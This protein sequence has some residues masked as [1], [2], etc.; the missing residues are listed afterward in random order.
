MCFLFGGPRYGE[1][2]TPP[3]THRNAGCFCWVDF[4]GVGGI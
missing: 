4:L 3:K 1:K 2:N